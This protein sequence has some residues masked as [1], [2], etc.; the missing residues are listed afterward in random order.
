MESLLHLQVG[1]SWP[2]NEFLRALFLPNLQSFVID[3]ALDSPIMALAILSC[4]S[5]PLRRLCISHSTVNSERLMERL[6]LFPLLSIIYLLDANGPRLAD[7]FHDRRK[8]NPDFLSSLQLLET[9]DDY[10]AFKRLVP[11]PSSTPDPDSSTEGIVVKG[12][13]MR[14]RRRE[15]FDLVMQRTTLHRTCDMASPSCDALKKEL[16]KRFK[17]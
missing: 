15:V 9:Y 11:I 8:S 13:D 6:A 5:P 3:R 14:Q 16:R 1:G 17:P 2:I 4:A 12:E 7:I 10:G